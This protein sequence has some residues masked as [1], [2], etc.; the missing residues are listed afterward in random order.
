MSIQ[1]KDPYHR[2]A[3]LK[4]PKSSHLKSLDMNLYIN[5]YVSE[6]RK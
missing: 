1:K 4:V 5:F 2:D 6:L 3:R